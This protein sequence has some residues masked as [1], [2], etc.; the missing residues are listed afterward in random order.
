VQAL[1]IS[2]AVAVASGSYHTIALRSDGLSFT[3]GKNS[4]GQVGD[5]TV[6]DKVTFVQAIGI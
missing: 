1:G 3:C 4:N 6:V 5:N 2:N